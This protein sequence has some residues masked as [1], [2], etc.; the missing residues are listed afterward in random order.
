MWTL[1]AAGGRPGH[2]GLRS[3]RWTAG[4]RPSGGMPRRRRPGRWSTGCAGWAAPELLA[5][6]TGLSVEDPS[7]PVN[8]ACAYSVVAARAGV[9]SESVHTG[10]IWYRPEVLDLAVAQDD[11]LVTASFRAPAASSRVVA[12][13][14]ET[15]PRS[16]TDGVALAATRRRVHRPVRAGRGHVPLPGV[17]RVRRAGRGRGVH[18]GPAVHRRVGQGPGAGGSPDGRAAGRRARV[19]VG[20]VHAA[21][22][23][24]R[25]A[26]VAGRPAARPRFP[27]ALVRPARRAVPGRAGRRRAAL[28]G[29]GPVGRPRRGHGQRGP[30]GR[31]RPRP[32]DPADRGAGRR[33]PAPG[34]RRARVLGLAARRGRDGGPLAGRRER[35]ADDDR[36]GRPLRGRRGRAPA[37][38]GRP[39]RDRGG[40]RGARGRPAPGRPGRAGPGRRAGRRRVH[41]DPLRVAAQGDRRHGH[42]RPA[43]GGAPAGAARLVRRLPPAALHRRPGARRTVPGGHCPRPARCPACPL[44]SSGRPGCAA[45][46]PATRSSCATRPRTSCG[47]GH[48]PARLP[49]LLRLQPAAGAGVPVRRPGGRPDRRVRAG[50]RRRA[51]AVPRGADLRRAAGVR[52]RRAAGP[53]GAP[54]LRSAL[55]APGLPVLPQRAAQRLL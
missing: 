48:D 39:D 32:V 9:Q 47:S 53:G 8:V 51:R 14:G 28:S 55:A 2:P 25:R 3:P 33:R 49:V 45:S 46:R 27:A 38:P 22:R 12:V 23:G 31:R 4:S 20:P 5:E 13:R 37:A 40:G 41:A 35:L 29:P 21:A 30:G 43:G 26:A 42:R 50:Q 1:C 24:V 19:P 6:T 34:R 15:P 54:G 44:P 10:A 17:R 7:P 11:G 18:P 52:G 36:L 16:P